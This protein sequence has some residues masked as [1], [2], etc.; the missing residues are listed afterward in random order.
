MMMMFFGFFLVF[1]HIWHEWIC[2]FQTFPGSPSLLT[3]LL[4]GVVNTS[5]D[6]V[7]QGEA[8]GGRLSPQLAIDL[9]GQHLQQTRG[10][11]GWYM[12]KCIFFLFFLLF[13]TPDS[14][15]DR[16]GCEEKQRKVL[17]LGHVVVVLG[18]VGELLIWRELH[19][20]VIVAV[21][22]HGCSCYP[23]WDEEANGKKMLLLCISIADLSD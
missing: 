12:H 18:E 14:V 10:I 8:T 6:D 15:I 21:L 7:I 2:S 20:V 22:C 4:T 19:L 16:T 23:T 1:F 11:K 9:L 3:W 17:D 5:L 13:L